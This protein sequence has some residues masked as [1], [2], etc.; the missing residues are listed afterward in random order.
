MNKEYEYENEL[1]ID[2]KLLCSICLNPFT[3]P[4]LTLCEHIFCRNCLELW[5]KTK[6][7]CPLCRQI[8]RKKDIKSLNDQNILKKI[9]QLYVKCLLCEQTKIRR[10]NFNYHVNNQCSKVVISCPINNL[11]CSWKGQREDSQSHEINC[12]YQ[13]NSHIEKIENLINQCPINSKISLNNQQI[14]DA[15]IPLIIKL[16][17]KIKECKILDLSRNEI[18]SDGIFQLAKS[19]E[20]N[21]TLK[22]LSFYESSLTEISI[23]YLAEKL[24]LNNSLLKWLDLESTNVND[25]SAEYLAIMLIK[26]TTLTGLWLSNNQIGYHGVKMLA[27]AII[28][29]NTKLKYL[30]LENNPL[31]NDSSLDDLIKMIKYNQSLKTVYLNNCQLSITS[32]I[33]LRDLAKTKIHFRLIL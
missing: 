20:N 5:L 25:I 32:Q 29:Y 12:S 27:S 23:L 15:D 31:I 10:K 9:N 28:N 1:S 17:I 14:T 18:N 8:I 4:K 19:L 26:N 2:G 6:S 11:K 21:K 33:K 7:T 30:D 3:Q 24:S 22:V 16:A 13:T